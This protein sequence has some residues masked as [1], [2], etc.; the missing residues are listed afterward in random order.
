MPVPGVR[1]V[2][3]APLV[4]RPVPS[5]VIAADIDKGSDAPPKAAPCLGLGSG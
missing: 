5:L 3:I 2:L 1:Q 4:R